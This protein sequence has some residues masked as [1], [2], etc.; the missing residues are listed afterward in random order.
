MNT[1]PPSPAPSDSDPGPSEPTGRFAP[2]AAGEMATMFDHVAARYDLL[3]RLMTLGQD[4]RWRRALAA[5][6]SDEARVVL[7]LCTGNGV[8]LTGLRRPGRLL[9]GVDVSLGMLEMARGE[10]RRTGW[11]PRLVCG[12]AFR[13]PIRARSI[14]VVTVAFGLRNLRPAPDALDELKRVL[15]PGGTLAVLEGCAPRPGPLAGL[16]RWHLR[17]VVPALGRLSPDPSAYRYLGESILAFDP[18]AFEAAL[19]GAGFEVVHHQAFLLGASRLWVARTLDERSVVAD[20]ASRHGA[21]HPA[22]SEGGVGAKARERRSGGMEWRIWTIVQLAVALA[23]AIVLGVGLWS[24][25]NSPGRLPLTPAMER[26][27]RVLLIGG[28]VAFAFRTVTLALRLTGRGP[29]P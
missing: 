26:L 1:A 27:A 5:E 23:L 24:L 21:L 15:V 2:H 18:A 29:R 11:A 12:D 3:N 28:I 14:D 17:V 4:A 25:D 8:S 13:L 16:H 22:R 10:Q 6:V 7:D 20:G 19:A 9:L